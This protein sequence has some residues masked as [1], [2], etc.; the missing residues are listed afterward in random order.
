MVSDDAQG[1]TIGAS[2]GLRP[3][4]GLLASDPAR[5][6]ARAREALG[7]APGDLDAQLL[8][9]SALRLQARL[10]DARAVLEPLAASPSASWVALYELAQVLFGLGQSRA[11][12]DPL[13]RA[14]ALNP[15]L[16][17]GWRLMGDIRLFSGEVAAAQAAYD[18]M[19]GAVLGDPRLHASAAALAEGRPEAAERDLRAILAR[20]PA[21]LAAAHLLGEALGRQG[22]LAD[23]EALLARCAAQAPNAYLVRQSLALALFR[24]GKPV[25]ALAELDRLLARDPRDNRCLMVKAAALAEIGDHAAAVEV[26]MSLLQVFPDQPQGW[27]VLGHGLR[28]L[29]RSGEAIAAYN[30]RLELDP[31]CSEALW[32]LANLKTYRFTEAACARSRPGWRG[33][34]CGPRTAPLHFTLGKARRT[35]AATPRPSSTMRGATRPSARAA[36]TT[37]EATSAFVRRC[38]ALLTPAFFAERAGW[39]VD[40]P[41]PIFIVGLPRS[42]S[43]LIEQILA[44]HPAV[45]GTQ[46]LPDIQADRRLG[47]AQARAPRRL[48]RPAGRDDAASSPQLGE[49]YLDRTR[50]HRQAGRPLF[51]D[52]MPN[53]FLHI[54]LIRLILPNARIID[55]RRH[56]LGCCFSA[57]KQHFAARPGL[58]L[59]PG[60]LGRYYADYVDLMAHFD[61]VLPGR[62]HR[63][64]YER[65]VD[66]TEAEVRRLLAYLRP[67]VRPGLP[68][69]LRE[70]PGRA[71]AQLRAGPPADLH[72]PARPLAPLRALARP[73]EGGARA[74]AGRLSRPAAAAPLA[75]IAEPLHPGRELGHHRRQFGGV[76][77]PVAEAAAVQ[78]L[79]APGGRWGCAPCA[80]GR[81]R[82]RRPWPGRPRSRGS[83]RRR[84]VRRRNPPP[85][86][87]GAPPAGPA[88][89]PPVGLRHRHAGAIAGRGLGRSVK[90]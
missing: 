63:V 18:R 79:R 40:A 29:G 26:T 53:N 8:L 57:F 45:E 37:P 30:R 32:S 44:S 47:G 12:T 50:V 43:T 39:G 68:E 3:A 70:S 67:A 46:E 10:D 84:P 65:L 72:R 1:P 85:G 15:G 38:K 17:G 66:D 56:P 23:A 61:A 69:V 34:T 6:E 14:L 21:A 52:K 90:A 62:I 83:P 82:R 78:P 73:A 28:T 42:G 60:D 13:A 74:G 11:A 5:A 59:R 20:E 27:L 71:H 4:I 80:A 64:I 77:A 51:I 58:L 36:P 33:P 87:R 9:G 22:R 86:P 54:G 35:P 24:A 19:L 75:R 76:G 55:A 89:D 2:A 81:W 49:D 41:D 31:D 48:S 7:A 88:A 25:Q 16:A